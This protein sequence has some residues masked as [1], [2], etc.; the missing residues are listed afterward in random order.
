M[1]ILYE[2]TLVEDPAKKK[3]SYIARLD[4]GGLSALPSLWTVIG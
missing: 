1:T 2:E 3:L 4:S